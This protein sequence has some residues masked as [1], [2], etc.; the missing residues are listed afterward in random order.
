MIWLPTMRISLG[1]NRNRPKDRPNAPISI[2]QSG[3]AT[4][5]AV[6]PDPRACTM[7]ASGPTALATSLAPCAKDSSAADTTSGM[8][9]STLS[10]LL[11]FSSPRDW[12]RITGIMTIQQTRP[13]TAPI[14]SAPEK[15]TS[16]IRL[17]P[18]SAR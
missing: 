12:R 11:R 16:K 17:R 7:A 6:P 9:N 4:A 5:S 1:P 8:P 2:T 15:V 18:F 14:I 10:D 13:S 3:M